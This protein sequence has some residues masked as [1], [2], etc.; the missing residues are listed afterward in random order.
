[1]GTAFQYVIQTGGIDTEA[2]YPYTAEDGTCQFNKV[3]IG[4][5]IKSWTMISQNETQM[6]AALVA[7]G[8]L[9]VA[10]DATSWQFY[11]GGVLYNPVPCGTSLDHGVLIVGYDTETTIIG[12]K[13]PYWIIKNSW[14]SSWGESGYIYI[15]RGDGYCGVNLY[16]CTSSVN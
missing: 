14:G 16:C 11:V 15:E 10:V 1:M 8:P 2:S 13:M 4:A 7:R 12:E 3:N 9:S 5:S 6:A